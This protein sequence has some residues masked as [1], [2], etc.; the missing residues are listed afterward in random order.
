MH[1]SKKDFEA[2]SIRV[3]RLEEVFYILIGCV[4]CASEQDTPRNLGHPL[5]TAS[6]SLFIRISSFIF[7]KKKKLNELLISVLASNLLN[8]DR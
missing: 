2:P 7:P 5:C 8:V 1:F 4:G 6:R 3:V